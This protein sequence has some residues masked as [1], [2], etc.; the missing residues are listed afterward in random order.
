MYGRKEFEMAL[1]FQ[2]FLNILS[3]D[4]YCARAPVNPMDPLGDDGAV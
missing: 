1:D 2:A 4:I 3:G